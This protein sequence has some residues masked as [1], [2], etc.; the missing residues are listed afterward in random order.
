[1][2]ANLHAPQGCHACGVD[3]ADAIPLGAAAAPRQYF[4]THLSPVGAGRAIGVAQDAFA[5]SVFFTMHGRSGSTAAASNG[6]RI[7]TTAA[8]GLSVNVGRTSP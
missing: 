6:L 7:T 4:T 5:H 3:S 8:G 1:M 2:I